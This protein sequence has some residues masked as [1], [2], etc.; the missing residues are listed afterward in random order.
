LL[1]ELLAIEQG[2][3]ASGMPVSGRHRDLMT[4]AK[5]A[6]V[7]CRLSPDGALD[8]IGLLAP[9]T[10]AKLWMWGDGNHNRFPFIH[11]NKPLLN[12]PPDK[13]G[14]KKL[15]APERRKRLRELAQDF[16]CDENWLK[17]WPKP[18]LIASLRQRQPSLAALNGSEAAAVP[19]VVERFL[20]ASRDRQAFLLKLKDLLFSEAEN[21]D[22]EWLDPAYRLLTSGGALYV[23]VLRGEF[24]RDVAYPGHVGA[25]SG[26]FARA[27]CE[28]PYGPCALLG[29]TVPLQAGSFPKPNLRLL[30]ETYIFSKN[31]D[32]PATGRYGRYAADAFPVGSELIERLAEAL[33]ELTAEHRRGLTWRRIPSERP[34][35]NDLLLAFVRAAPDAPVTE[36]IADDEDQSALQRASYLR[37]AERVIDAIK[38]KVGED[39]R[40]TPVDVCVFRKVDPGNSKVVYHRATS[41]GQLWD[42]AWAAA[43][44]NVPDWLRMPV[45]GAR[46]GKATWRSPPHVA[47]LQLPGVMRLQYIRGGKEKQEVTGLSARDAFS[48]F[49]NDSDASRRAR[50]G[51]RLVMERHGPLLAEGAQALRK[52]FDRARAFDRAAALQSLTLLGVLLSKIGRG[53]ETYMDETAFKLG[54]LL[55]I[56]DTV[57]VGYCADRRGGDVPPALLG[58][59]V[60]TMAQSSPSRAL[61]ALCR[62]WKPYGAWAKLPTT[63]E[64]GRSLRSSKDPKEVTRG[65]DITRG[66]SSASRAADLTRELHGHLPTATNDAFR[67]E[68]LLGYVAGLARR[69]KVEDPPEANEDTETE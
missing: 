5:I 48:L 66:A 50:L 12:M 17:S 60:L 45:P 23:D 49:L 52:G 11:L 14:Q 56:A 61:A 19:A 36:I 47:P 10:V 15:P 20:T 64:L 43:E 9:E 3:T 44:N 33:R 7:Q 39:F 25:I 53:K 8:E 18:A 38:G 65:W 57:H 21:G 63:R 24:A 67:A 28:V 13:Y 4:P 27:D 58:N 62:R 40:R 32:I 51:L 41:V 69:E 26:A 2:L 30:G 59:S 35:Q 34:K 31:H 37:R 22:P 1:N 54:Q 42:A 46:G 16:C 55:A 29:E 6:A 68:L